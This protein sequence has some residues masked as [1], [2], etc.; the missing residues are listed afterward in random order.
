MGWVSGIGLPFSQS[1]TS[2]CASA[3]DMAWSWSLAVSTFPFL[4][5]CP[6]TMVSHTHSS[7][8]MV[9][10]HLH[11]RPLSHMPAYPTALHSLVLPCMPLCSIHLPKFY[12]SSV[13]RAHFSLTQGPSHISSF[14]HPQTLHSPLRCRT[15]LM[16]SHGVICLGFLPSPSSLLPLVYLLTLT[17]I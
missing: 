4:F 13:C 2:C 5:H 8:H 11:V 15:C 12:P 1:G 10:L 16:P 14:P 3:R 9:F 17:P 6:S 7:R